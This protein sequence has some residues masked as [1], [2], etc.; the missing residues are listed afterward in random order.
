MAE[1]EDIVLE[2]RDARSAALCSLVEEALDGACKDMRDQTSTAIDGKT[3]LH[4]SDIVLARFKQQLEKNF[5]ELVKFSSR[6]DLDISSTL[7]FGN[8]RLIEEDDLE[9]IIAMEGMI[10]HARNTDIEQYLCYTTR[11]DKLIPQTKID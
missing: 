8:L 3:L 9:A 11:L 1:I 4:E 2:V 6:M 7:D 5:T 10:A